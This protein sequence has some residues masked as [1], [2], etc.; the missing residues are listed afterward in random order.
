MTTHSLPPHPPLPTSPHPHPPHPPLPILPSSPVLLE[1][2]PICICGS[3][4]PHAGQP[5]TGYPCWGRATVPREPQ[6]IIL[7]LHHTAGWW[8]VPHSP[9]GVGQT[10]AR[11]QLLPPRTPAQVTMV[12]QVTTRLSLQLHLSTSWTSPRGATPPTQPTKIILCITVFSFLKPLD[13][14]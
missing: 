1:S 9:A 4:T 12:T 2:S 11:R 6:L 14:L 10:S 7:K 3:V 13:N 8:H 5:R